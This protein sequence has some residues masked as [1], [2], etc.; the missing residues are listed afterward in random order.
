MPE[1][2]LPA[3][4]NEALHE[5]L[6]ALAVGVRSFRALRK[7]PLLDVLHG[8]LGHHLV[9]RIDREAPEHLRLPSGKLVKLR[10]AEGEPP[11]LAVRI[12]Q[13]FGWQQTPKIAG[14]RVEVL[15]HLL[16]PNMRPQQITRDLASFWRNT[17]PQI[18]KELAGRY[19]RHAWPRDPLAAD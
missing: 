19:P 6:P 18:R 10:Y 4:D 15:L 9:Q 8:K 3:L 16:A 1:A 12:Q 7:A 5:L 17:Y 13:I 14:G 11:V 2:A